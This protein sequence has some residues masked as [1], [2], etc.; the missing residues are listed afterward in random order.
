MP[1]RMTPLMRWPAPAKLNL[2]LH[3]TG[4]RADGYH[5]LQTLFQFVDLIDWLTFTPNSSGAITRSRGVAGVAADEDLVVRAARLLQQQCGCSQGVD[6]AV[7]KVIPAGAG[8]GGG[9]SDAAT[10]LVALNRIWGC[11]VECQGL[12]EL[13]LQLGADVPIF[14]HGSAAWAEGV[15]EQITP[16]AP[17][18]PWYLL[19]SPEVAVS[20]AEIFH[21]RELTRNTPKAKI[22]GSL[23]DGGRNDCEPVV[24]GRYPEVGAALRWL[25]R[26]GEARMTGT[27]SCLFVAMESRE[28]AAAAQL[29][30]PRQWRGFVVRGM[31]RSPLLMQ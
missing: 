15:G 30:L 17:D 23:P 31:N 14:I 3:I 13:G 8:L 21:S 7:E 25:S 18:E 24:V 22:R 2:F 26:F 29:Q 6:I 12:A 20:T 28:A 10:T 11:G 1:S 9:S 4:R 5:E 19:L 27:G 16:V